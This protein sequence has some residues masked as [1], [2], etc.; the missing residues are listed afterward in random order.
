MQTTDYLNFI[1]LNIAVL[2][3][4][5]LIILR[6]T[7]YRVTSFSKLFL[8]LFILFCSQIII[9]EIVLGAFEILTYKNVSIVIYSI[10]ILLTIILGKKTF[11][12][13]KVEKFNKDYPSFFSTLAVF[14]PIG[15]L[16]FIKLP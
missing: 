11:K 13:F 9:V 12:N 14:G 10:S 6:I 1:G 5:L 7:G 8:S 15:F 2:F 16:M 4:S 3:S